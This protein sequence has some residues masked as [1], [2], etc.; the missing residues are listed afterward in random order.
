[1]VMGAD[2]VMPENSR[3]TRNAGK[4]GASPQAMVNITNRKKG[5]TVIQYLPY[6]SLVGAKTI[7]P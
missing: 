4:L 2:A 5:I 6:C 7:G 3:K 1:M